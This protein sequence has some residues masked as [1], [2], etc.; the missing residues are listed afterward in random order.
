MGGGSI[1]SQP[2]D[3]VAFENT[4]RTTCSLAGYPGVSAYTLRNGVDLKVWT[5]IHHGSIYERGD[6]GVRTVEIAPGGEA[7]FDIGS[8][9]AYQGG[10]DAVSINRLVVYPPG[11][12]VGVP[13]LMPFGASR[14]VGQAYPITVTAVYPPSLG[15]PPQATPPSVSAQAAAALATYLTAVTSGDCRRAETLV[16]PSAQGDGDLCNGGRPGHLVIDRWRTSGAPM[17]SGQVLIFGTELHVI[18]GLPTGEPMPTWYSWFLEFRPT[19][20]GWRLTAGGTGP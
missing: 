3:V 6:L 13:V 1:A 8:A 4:S 11:S 20:R 16:L 19:S 5:R 9:M 10:L 14:P 17:K 12:D 15:T 2:F 18:S 7:W